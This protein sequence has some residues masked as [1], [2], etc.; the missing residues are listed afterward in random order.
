MWQRFFK[1]GHVVSEKVG[2]VKVYGLRAT[3]RIYD[4][5]IRTLI[6]ID[7]N[8]PSGHVGYKKCVG[9]KQYI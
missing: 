1:F 7:N 5:R 4:D 8:G 6:A 9:H 2:V 3:K